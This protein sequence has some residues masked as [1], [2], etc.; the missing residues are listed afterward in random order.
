MIVS[1]VV[2]GLTATVALAFL[3]ESALLVAVTVTFVVLP[4]L[5][6]VN[7]PLLETLPALEDQFTAVLLVP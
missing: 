7:I 2:A 5:G 6:A 1:V 4:T 3:V